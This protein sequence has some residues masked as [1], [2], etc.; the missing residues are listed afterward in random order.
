MLQGSALALAMQQAVKQGRLSS[1]EGA[2]HLLAFLQ[3]REAKQHMPGQP[4]SSTMGDAVHSGQQNHS[5][6]AWEAQPAGSMWASEAAVAPATC[7]SLWPQEAGLASWGS[8]GTA[9]VGPGQRS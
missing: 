2:A 4:C 7:P 1:A 8:L 9:V 5:V 3:Q 6:P